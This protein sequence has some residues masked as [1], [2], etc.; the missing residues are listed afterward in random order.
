MKIALAS[1]NA[2]KVREFNELLGHQHELVTMADLGI[3]SPEETGLTFIENAIL[4]ARFVAEHT[5]LPTLADDS[6]LCV[7]ALGGAPGLYSSR[8]AGEPGNHQHNVA[9]LLENMQSLTGQDRQAYFYCIVVY[10]QTATDPAPLIGE[11]RWHGIILDK[12]RGQGGFGYDPI[13]GADDGKLSSAE[14][15]AATKNKLSHRRQALQALNLPF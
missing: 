3:E 15:D 11:G 9:K 2:G 10:L 4:K 12:P 14:L 5:D 1:N 13:F 6:G 8:Y 7:P